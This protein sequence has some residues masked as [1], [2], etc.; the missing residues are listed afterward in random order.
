MTRF[1]TKFGMS[2]VHVT[3][4]DDCYPLNFLTGT[5]TVSAASSGLLNAD[6]VV[7]RRVLIHPKG[8]GASVLVIKN[9]VGDGALLTIIA[10]D[11][12]TDQPLS[13]EYGLEVPNGFYATNSHTARNDFTI[14]FE[15]LAIT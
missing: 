13:F 8:A 10:T 15:E 2:Q 4:T 1:A 7:I 11:G 6:A 14:M 3:T 5:K 12:A 9:H